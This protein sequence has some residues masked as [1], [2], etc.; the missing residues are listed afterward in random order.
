MFSMEEGEAAVRTARSTIERHLKGES[1]EQ[2]ALPQK[3]QKEMGVFVTINR[4]P[5]GDLRG[6]IGFPEPIMKLEDALKRAAVSAT[7]DPRFAP[8]RA[9]E[10]DTIVVEVTLLTPPEEVDCS[11]EGLPDHITC[12]EDGLVI[13]FRNRSGLLL[14]Q[15]PV[16]QGWDEREFLDHTCLKAGLPSGFWKKEGCVVKK[17]QGE[18]FKEEEPGGNI[19]RKE[20]C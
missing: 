19:K 16:E 6:C 13:S 1:V 2:G 5:S 20:L 18:I 9:D 12:G 15:V 8:L 11:K 17:F 3:F 4:H 7:R 14:P 10:L